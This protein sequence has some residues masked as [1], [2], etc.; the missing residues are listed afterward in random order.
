M[1]EYS[2]KIC[3]DALHCYRN[4]HLFL[5]MDWS[6]LTDTCMT[7]SLP[8]EL[9]DG[10]L[11]IISSSSSLVTSNATPTERPCRGPGLST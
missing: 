11:K 7:I 6:T 8:A 3:R 4:G 9:K 2:W 1:I 10:W 5:V